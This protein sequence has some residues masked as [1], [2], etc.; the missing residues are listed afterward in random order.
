MD[1]VPKDMNLIRNAL[2]DK[3]LSLEHDPARDT[4]GFADYKRLLDV[5]EEL[6]LRQ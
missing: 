6:I 2:R 3:V 5:F 4:K 1:I